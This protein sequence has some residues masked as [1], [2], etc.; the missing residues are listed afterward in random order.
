MGL[1]RK[2]PLKKEIKY[3]SISLGLDNPT[4]MIDD[5]ILTLLVIVGQSRKLYFFRKSF[6][7]FIYGRFWPKKFYEYRNKYMHK[8]PRVSRF[9]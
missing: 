3:P 4:S 2:S 9:Y 8:I 1:E 7:V 5:P 6:T